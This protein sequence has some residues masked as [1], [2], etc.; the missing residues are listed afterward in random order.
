MR[1]LLFS[2][3]HGNKKI[4]ERLVEKA[5]E[6][7]IVI[8]A[9]DFG[10]MR[11]G[12]AATIKYLQ[13]IKKP[14]IVVPG[15]AE[16]FEELQQA[17]KDWQ[18]AHVLHGN[19]IVIEDIHFFGIGGGIPVTPF[20]SW[21]YDYSEKEAQELLKDCPEKAVLVSHSPPRGY[22]DIASNG[23]RFGSTSIMETAVNKQAQLVVCGHIHESGGKYEYLQETPVVNAGPNGMIWEI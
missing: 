13:P 21:S 20:G 19:G 12:I 7:D 15:N 5:R 16:S 11:Q 8:G 22:V 4:C 14:A 10:N 9:G 17:C 23:H 6:A 1:L 2:D 18:T 3:V